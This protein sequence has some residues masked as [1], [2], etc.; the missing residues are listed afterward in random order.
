[1]RRLIL[2]RHAKSSWDDPSLPDHDRPLNP[3]GMA[4][5]PRMG[6]W[7]AAEGLVPDHVACSSSVRTLETWR[8]AS[9]EMPGAPQP[10]VTPPIYEADVG[11]L[12]GVIQG[13]PAGAQ[14]VMAIGHEPT[15]SGLT[16]RLAATPVSTDCARAFE[17]FPTAAIA[18][19]DVAIEGWRDLRFGAAHFT[20]FV[21]PREL[22]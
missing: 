17:K 15:M 21:V 22:G 4:A 9:A 10:V 1:M 19:F 5:A 12:M 7:L 14:T 2:F 20:R 16:Y 11:D 3:R 18:V 13:A 8:L 6:A